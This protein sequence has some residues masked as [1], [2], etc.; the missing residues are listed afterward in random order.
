ML[1]LTLVSTNAIK[2]P[3]R[4]TQREAQLIARGVDLIKSGDL[5]RVR[6]AL[7]FGR[8]RMAALLDI[9]EYTLRSWELDKLVPNDPRRLMKIGEVVG[10]LQDAIDEERAGTA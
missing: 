9:S 3:S 8:A 1:R 7:H 10:K 5:R 6:E 2:Y 4:L